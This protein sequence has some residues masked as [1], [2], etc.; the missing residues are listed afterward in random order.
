MLT[1]F[2]SQTWAIV[3]SGVEFYHLLFNKQNKIIV[4]LNDNTSAEKMKK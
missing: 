1:P 3:A 4:K 2:K